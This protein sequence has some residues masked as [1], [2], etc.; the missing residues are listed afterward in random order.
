MTRS[1]TDREDIV[2]ELMLD[3]GTPGDPLLKAALESIAGLAALP[4]PAPRGDLALLLGVPSAASDG[5]THPRVDE[6]AKRRRLKSR[7]AILA[8]AVVATMGLGIGSV[9][10]SG[11]FPEN[12][13]E[14]VTSLI[15]GWGP[16]GNPAPSSLVPPVPAP[17]APTVTTVPG[18][19]DP[20]AAEPGTGAPLNASPQSPGGAPA[21]SELP[22]AQDSVPA[23]PGRAPAA[24]KKASEEKP[25][26]KKTDEE[27]AAGKKAANNDAANKNA[28]NKNA[29]A[30]EKA[31][32]NS[33]GRPSTVRPEDVVNV[34]RRIVPFG[35]AF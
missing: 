15:S 31:P 11:G 8:G 32:G 29:A 9:A 20:P 25:G 12:P 14:F 27:K 34:L 26:G 33:V 19:A 23:P 7:P 5:G 16:H 6:L 35:I 24:E 2:S 22:A 21:G 4:A 13:P 10:A 1:H 3:A 28:A 18:P 17:D 30:E